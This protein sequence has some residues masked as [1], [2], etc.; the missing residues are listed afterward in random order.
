VRRFDDLKIPDLLFKK[1][2]ENAL[3]YCK[4]RIALNIW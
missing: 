4:K 2:D 1:R 3:Q